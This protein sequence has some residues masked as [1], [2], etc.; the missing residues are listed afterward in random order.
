[1][2]SSKSLKVGNRVKSAKLTAKKG[3][4][5]KTVVK[6]KLPAIWAKRSRLAR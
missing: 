5:D 2:T 3:T 4:I 1:M 6:V